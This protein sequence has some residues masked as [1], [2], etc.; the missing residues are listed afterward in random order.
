VL[1]VIALAGGPAAEPRLP[2]AAEPQ[3][4]PAGATAPLR[5]GRWTARD[6]PPGWSLLRGAGYQVQSQV[7]PAVAVQVLAH[8]EALA[9]L[10]AEL[11]GG[12]GR[13]SPGVIKL[14]GDRQLFAE[15]TDG[16]GLAAE[17]IGVFDPEAREILVLD[18]GRLFDERRPSAALR[19]VED[20]THRLSHADLQRILHLLD[21]ATTAWTDDTARTAA[22]ESWHHALH[23]WLGSAVPPPQWLDEGLADWFAAADP[24]A[25]GSPPGTPPV[26]GRIHAVRARELFRALE[27]GQLLS[28]RDMLVRG[29]N[30]YLV[31]PE[32]AYAQ[33]WSMVHFLLC[34]PEPEVRELP[35]RLLHRFRDVKHAEQATAETFADVDLDALGEAWHSWIVHLPAADPLADLAREFGTRLQPSDLQGPLAWRQ[36]YAWYRSNPHAPTR[37]PLGGPAPQDG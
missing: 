12:G 33:G 24:P 2:R 16:L 25:E 7:A 1:G 31:R 28:F 35:A 11:L 36:A 6:V 34:H 20:A 19:L 37:R 3:A 32:A 14:I 8:V 9:P 29:D 26:T 23:D 5:R 15:L 22:H 21:Q 27:D 30:Q 10:Q 17:R 4:R 13:R 18:S